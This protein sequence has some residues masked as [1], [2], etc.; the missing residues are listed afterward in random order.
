M[1]IRRLLDGMD[2]RNLSLLAVDTAELALRSLP[3]HDGEDPRLHNV[4][5]MLREVVLGGD[6]D[7]P[8]LLVRLAEVMTCSKGRAAQVCSAVECATRA[9]SYA[10]FDLPAARGCLIAALVILR[11]LNPAA[12]VNLLLWRMSRGEQIDAALAVG[13]AARNVM[14]RRGLDP[15][16]QPYVDSACRLL[17]EF[18]EGGVYLSSIETGV[19]NQMD[20]LSASMQASRER[21]MALLAAEVGRAI[22]SPSDEETFAHVKT[23]FRYAEAVAPGIAADVLLAERRMAREMATA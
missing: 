17:G 4:V 11:D 7:F 3:R 13:E 22:V 6:V 20:Y 18:R 1:F 14:Q 16:I 9:L 15:A 5:R 8:D 23:A 21:T 12:V 2:A 10:G 19:I